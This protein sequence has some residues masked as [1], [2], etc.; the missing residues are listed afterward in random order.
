[1]KRRRRGSRVAQR[2]V[3]VAVTVVDVVKVTVDQVVDVVAVRHGRVAAVR[4][5]HVIGRMPAARV[6]WRAPGR[7]RGTDR[8][9]ALVDVIAVDSVEMAIVKVVHVAVVLDTSV[10]AVRAVDVV[11]VGVNLVLAHRR[12]LSRDVISTND[13]LIDQ[14]AVRVKHQP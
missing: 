7:V 6:V 13:E 8:D 4:A 14:S 3:V 5:V 2:A 11:V 10:A 12:I 1:M 9:R